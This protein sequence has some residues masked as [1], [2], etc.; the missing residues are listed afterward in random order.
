MWELSQECLTSSEYGNSKLQSMELR[1][2]MS[3]GR[4]WDILRHLKQHFHDFSP[5][6]G[7]S[8][9]YLEFIN[10]QKWSFLSGCKAIPQYTH[11]VSWL[12]PLSVL[13]FSMQLI[14]DLTP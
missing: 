12:K 10:T 14:N 5:Q 2:D 11:L 1:M 8:Q 9:L 13:F 6:Q 3:Q 7:G 4:P